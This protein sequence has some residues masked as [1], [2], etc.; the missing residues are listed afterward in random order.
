MAEPSIAH[1]YHKKQ[2]TWHLY[3]GHT[4]HVSNLKFD[5][6]KLQFAERLLKLGINHVA[7]YWPGRNRQDALG[8]VTW[9]FC[10]LQFE[11]IA[12]A[13]RAKVSLDGA[14]FGG[15]LMKVGIPDPD[16]PARCT[17]YHSW[18]QKFHTW[19]YHE[20]HRQA[21][22]LTVPTLLRHMVDNERYPESVY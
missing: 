17:A 18:V 11:D 3:D 10:R 1:S 15:R 6:T 13:A 9:P 8:N 19:Q 4:I 14:D 21:F 5:I 7:I 20:H 2:R 22:I 12:A 16:G